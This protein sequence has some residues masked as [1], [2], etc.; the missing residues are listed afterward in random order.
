[1]VPPF[2]AAQCLTVFAATNIIFHGSIVY[3]IARP[4]RVPLGK[5]DMFVAGLG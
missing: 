5:A 1:M 3:A 4:N 2:P